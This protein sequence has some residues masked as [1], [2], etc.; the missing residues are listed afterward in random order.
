MDETKKELILESDSAEQAQSEKSLD[1]ELGLEAPKAGEESIEALR[2]R[3]EKAEQ[4]RENYKKAFLK[5]K[6]G[7]VE[8]GEEEEEDNSLDVHNVATQAATQVI[9]KANERTAIEKFTSKYPALKDPNA[10]RKV[11]ESLSANI[12]KSSVQTIEMELEAAL[13]AA[14]VKGGGKVA[15]K[16]VSLN[17]YA[18]VS[19]AGSYTSP[20][21]N[22]ELSNQS[23]E[24][25]RNF[26]HTVED[27]KSASEEGANEIR[28]S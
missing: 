12:D 24:L 9:E 27:L 3:A 14:K 4:D 2:A 13:A 16:E 22:V 6:K 5:A 18:S 25:G 8:E 28:I 15:E 10:W 20:D 17:K 11:V 21:E 1:E 26:G 19:H 7:D 23:I